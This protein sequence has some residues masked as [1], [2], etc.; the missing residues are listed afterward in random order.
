MAREFRVGDRIRISWEKISPWHKRTGTITEI[1]NFSDVDATTVY[2]ITPD[3]PTGLS[4]APDG[5]GG[6]F[7]DRLILLKPDDEITEA[8]WRWFDYLSGITEEKT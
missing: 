5:T 4:L 6:F 7:A 3:D 1:T 2:R 8:T